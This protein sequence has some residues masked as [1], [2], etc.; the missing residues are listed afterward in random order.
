MLT[1][2]SWA[3]SAEARVESTESF[4]EWLQQQRNGTLR[5]VGDYQPEQF[6][7]SVIGNIFIVSPNVLSNGR[8]ELLNYLREQAIS[9]MVHRYGNL[10]RAAV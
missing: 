5:I 1:E 7:P 9:E 10:T 8:I 4:V 2:V 3:I 6:A